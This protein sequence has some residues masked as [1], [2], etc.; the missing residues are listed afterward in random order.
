[1][2]QTISLFDKY[3]GVPTIT[4]VVR[5]FYKNVLGHPDFKHYFENIDMEKLIMHQIEFISYAMGK[6]KSD[7]PDAKLYE[8]HKNLKINDS[9][10]DKIAEILKSVLIEFK[11]EKNDIL[12][13]LDAVESKRKLIV[14]Y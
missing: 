12:K 11:V 7:Y 6:P 14:S 10:F 5:A 3:G 13:I 9:Q 2:N 1:M 4:E 8:G